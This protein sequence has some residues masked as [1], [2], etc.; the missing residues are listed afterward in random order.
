MTLVLYFMIV[1]CIVCW[2]ISLYVGILYCMLQYFIVSWGIVLY[3]AV[4][5]C[6]MGCSVSLEDVVL[7][8]VIFYG[9][10]SNLFSFSAVLFY[11]FSF[12]GV[13]CFIEGSCALITRPTPPTPGVTCCCFGLCFQ[14]P[15]SIFCTFSSVC[16]PDC[17]LFGCS[18]LSFFFLLINFFVSFSFV[19]SCS[20]V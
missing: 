13:V 5:Y 12:N 16:L 6:I 3:V 7:R 17:C 2:C 11:E 20:S 14:K 19:L 4:L 10:S 9:V 18:L 15:P 1:Y 8:G